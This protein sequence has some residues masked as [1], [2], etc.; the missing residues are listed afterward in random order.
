MT[1]PWPNIERCALFLQQERQ[2]NALSKVSKRFKTFFAGGAHS[3]LPGCQYVIDL[4]YPSLHGLPGKTRLAPLDLPN[5]LAELLC[6]K[7][8]SGVRVVPVDFGLRLSKAGARAAPCRLCQA[9]SRSTSTS[10]ADFWAFFY[11]PRSKQSM[12]RCVSFT[13]AHEEN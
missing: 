2:S 6:L 8:G 13:R 12:P 11:R 9:V 7:A 10:V 3:S 4:P 5:A 1:L